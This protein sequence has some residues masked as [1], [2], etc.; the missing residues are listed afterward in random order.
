[1]E[2]GKILCLGGLIRGHWTAPMAKMASFRSFGGYPFAT[3]L[4]GP[5]G[6]LEGLN[7]GHGT[8]T[9]GED[10]GVRSFG[11]WMGDTRGLGPMEYLIAFMI[12]V[13]V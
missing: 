2:F 12:F 1:L 4:P 10:G 6:C 11:V 5:I 13:C 3:L 7:R 8:Y 9:Y